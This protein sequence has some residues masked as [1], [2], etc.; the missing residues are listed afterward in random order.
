MSWEMRIETIALSMDASCIAILSMLVCMVFKHLDLGS[1]QVLTLDWLVSVESVKVLW[2]T[3]YQFLFIIT[4]WFSRDEERWLRWWITS[5]C[6]M[7]DRLT[8][9][10]L[11]N[12][13]GVLKFITREKFHFWIAP[14]GN[15][16]V[17]LNLS[18]Q[19]DQNRYK[20]CLIWTSGS[21]IFILSSHM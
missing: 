4:S 5:D 1:T 15:I 13:E 17:A 19:E 21:G 9:G 8:G 10:I 12:W 11:S 16:I 18:L 2:L 6:M 3:L 14:I 20:F 7:I